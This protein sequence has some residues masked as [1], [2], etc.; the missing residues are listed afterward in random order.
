ML[1]I[2]VSDQLQTPRGIFVYGEIIQKAHKPQK[3]LYGN[4][5]TKKVSKT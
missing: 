2:R 3:Y 5:T 4:K 1:M